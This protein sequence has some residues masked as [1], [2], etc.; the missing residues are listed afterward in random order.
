MYKHR[1]SN[2]QSVVLYLGDL[3]L[4]GD[5]NVDRLS[6][7]YGPPNDCTTYCTDICG[8]RPGFPLAA[9]TKTLSIK[10]RSG[11]VRQGDAFNLRYSF[12]HATCGPSMLTAS[13]FVIESPRLLNSYPPNLECTWVIELEPT[14]VC[15]YC[16]NSLWFN[17]TI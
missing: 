15:H 10:F 1:I 9:T 3:S 17:D 8:E 13:Q 4:H 6:I 16:Y 5:C 14:Q 2:F 11:G 12:T 7:S